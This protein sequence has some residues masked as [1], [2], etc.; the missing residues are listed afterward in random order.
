VALRN[1]KSSTMQRGAALLAFLGL[2]VSLGA[3]LGCLPE[4]PTAEVPEIPAAELPQAP[5]V[6]VPEFQPPELEAPEGPEVPVEPPKNVGNCCLRTGKA[7]KEKCGGAMSCCTDKFEDT[8]A[9]LTEKGYWFH[10]EEGCAG[11]C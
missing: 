6:Q 2:C 7:H 1:M 9:C 4:I 3:P 11:A 5:E 10:S 8:A